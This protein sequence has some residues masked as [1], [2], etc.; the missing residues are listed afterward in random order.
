MPLM[1]IFPEL[2]DLHDVSGPW[3]KVKAIPVVQAIWFI[4]VENGQNALLWPW[5]ESFF[6]KSVLNQKCSISI[7]WGVSYLNF[8][9][10]PVCKCVH[11]VSLIYFYYV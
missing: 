9:C 1:G 2:G 3:L 7:S 8:P 10:V 4:N 6:F 5:F 11:T